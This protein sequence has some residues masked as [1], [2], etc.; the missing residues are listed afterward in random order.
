MIVLLVL[1]PAMCSAKKL[2]TSLPIDLPQD[3]MYAYV[4]LLYSDDL[5]WVFGHWV[6]RY[7]RPKIRIVPTSIT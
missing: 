7:E 3:K 6:S 1:H 4:T 5:L 2:F